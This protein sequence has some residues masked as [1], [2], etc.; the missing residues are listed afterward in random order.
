MKY[1][2]VQLF[3]CGLLFSGVVLAQVKLESIDN[4]KEPAA[5]LVEQKLAEVG[6]VKNIMVPSFSVNFVSKSCLPVAKVKTPP[7]STAQ[8]NVMILTGVRDHVYQQI[9]DEAYQYY[10]YKLVEKGFIILDR[11]KF[12]QNYSYKTMVHNEP[13]NTEF[14]VQGD[15]NEPFYKL[16][17]ATH[18]RTF[19][20]GNN[21]WFQFMNAP[22]NLPKVNKMA[23][24]LQ[25]TLAEMNLTVDFL[26]YIA[27]KGKAE[28]CSVANTMG[29]MIPF[30]FDFK[31]KL[32]IL[33]HSANFV[34]PSYLYGNSSQKIN[35]AS[36]KKFF[37]DIKFFPKTPD[38]EL[39]FGKSAKFFELVA[40][41]QVYKATAIELLK[42]YIDG[43]VDRL[44]G[45]VPAE[46]V[47]PTKPGV[48]G[49]PVVTPVKK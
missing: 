14:K 30:N 42:K 15:V 25:A 38:L 44:M 11:D 19:S 16:S 43:T 21:I 29:I 20:A 4:V 35:I 2:N 8:N 31:P 36:D 33:S 27:Q 18:A 45:V 48:K 47:V 32:N 40:E 6:K 49:K 22:A 28:P 39:T 13:N 37:K 17:G 46:P 41:E 26:E 24:E 5:L 9:T 10:I 23:K 34:T 3:I 1:K 7:L 12:E